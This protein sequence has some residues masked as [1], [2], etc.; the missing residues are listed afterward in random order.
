MHS[1]SRMEVAVLSALLQFAREA[2]PDVEGL[3]EADDF[4]AQ[5][6][7]LIYRAVMRLWASRRVPDPLTVADAL[8]ASGDLD[9]VGGL[10]YLSSLIDA[11]ASPANVAHHAELVREA[12][13]LRRLARAAEETLRDVR[14]REGRS[15]QDLADAAESRILAATRGLGAGGFRGAGDL[16]DEALGDMDRAAEGKAVVFPSGLGGLDHMLG[17]GFRP[18][19][20]T[21][22]AARPSMGKS[23]LAMQLARQVADVVPVGVLS[24]EMSTRQLMSRML[25]AEAWVDSQGVRTGRVDAEARARL[26]RAADALRALPLFADDRPG[27]TIAE[28]RSRVRRLVSG[29]GAR[30]VIVDYLQLLSGTRGREGNRVQEV[31]EISRS[32]KL[33]AIELDVHVL[34]VSQLSRGVDARAEKRP[35]LSDL[36]ESGSIEQDADTV[37]FLYRPD[38]YAPPEQAAGLRGVAELIVAKQRNG[39]TGS[40]SLKFERAYGRFFE[41]AFPQ[42]RRPA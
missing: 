39:P 33:I 8:E 37:A 38:Y 32:L 31:S 14:E 40:L 26:D 5:R 11:V 22:L 19:D 1:A 4:E 20:L 28:V 24:L 30:V 18:G 9:Q 23:A 42:L 27:Q 16:V 29:Q 7:G 6:H 25:S 12:A 17:G 13:T 41:P 2:C 34:A 35:L 15:V 10:D 36:R 21:V 3:L